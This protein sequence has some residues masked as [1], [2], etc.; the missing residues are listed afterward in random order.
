ML[1]GI[2][3]PLTVLQVL[4]IDLGMDIMPSLSLIM[5]PPEPD[6][7]TR[8]L[9]R[10]SRLIDAR[11]LLRALY[12]GL[13]VGSVALWWAFNIWSR[14]GWVFGQNTVADPTEYARGTTAVMVAIMT[15]QLGNIFA[16]RASRESTFAVSLLRNKWLFIGILAQIGILMAIVYVP[17]LQSLFGTASLPFWDLLLIYSLAPLVLFLEELRKSF[18]RRI[19]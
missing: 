13:V 1:L 2:P 18:V 3:L 14:A 5:E 7:L 12:L 15:G 6:V 4:A 16:A 11:I 17:F 10:R 19:K 9:K 8:S